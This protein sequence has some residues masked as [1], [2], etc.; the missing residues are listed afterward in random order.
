MVWIVRHLSAYKEYSLYHILLEF[1]PLPHYSDLCSYCLVHYQIHC[2]CFSYSRSWRRDYH[3][4][5]R[6]NEAELEKV[7]NH[8]QLFNSGDGV[9]R[10]QMARDKV[11]VLGSG[12]HNRNS[13]K[14]KDAMRCYSNLRTVNC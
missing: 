3:P 13:P 14:R 10:Q 12:R 11:Q 5:S 2:L 1:E 9:E 8:G 7:E 6:L 4:R